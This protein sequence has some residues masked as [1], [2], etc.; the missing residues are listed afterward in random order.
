MVLSPASHALP[1]DKCIFHA[2]CKKLGG[3]SKTMNKKEFLEINPVLPRLIS[4]FPHLAGN[5][6][7]DI[8][9]PEKRQAARDRPSPS[10]HFFAINSGTMR[11]KFGVLQR[12]VLT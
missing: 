12:Q 4:G 8:R 6:R 10:T 2:S 7:L 9:T 1:R 11:F 5:S 3:V